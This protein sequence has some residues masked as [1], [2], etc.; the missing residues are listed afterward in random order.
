MAILDTLNILN[1]YYRIKLLIP[2]R[3]QILLRR[4]VVLAKMRSSTH[5]WP[6]NEEAGK[7]PENW[8]GWPVGKRFALVLTHDVDTVQGQEK[9]LQLARLERELGFRSAFNFVIKNDVSP[10]LRQNLTE[11]GFE[12]GVH[13]LVH[14]RS[15]YESREAFRRQAM[16]IN[17]YVA[18]WGAVG[19]RSPSMY[20][21][22]EW[23]HDLAVE[24]DAS[25]F[26]TD[27]FEPQPDGVGTIFPFFVGRDDCGSGYIELPYTLPQD[28]T[29]FILLQERDI[30]IWKRKLDWIAE[31]GGMA[32]LNTHPDY[33]RF[34][35]TGKAYEEYP[36][37]YYLEF[38]DYAKSR[39][40]KHFWHALPR[41][42]AKF[43][44]KHVREV[45]TLAVGVPPKCLSTQHATPW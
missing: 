7:P 15:L 45:S 31:R 26:D 42:I 16:I 40:G 6:I 1:L 25:T 10:A 28:F 41:E 20:H 18:G 34:A 44:K 21:N 19:F 43:Q 14:D 30:R 37:G 24:Y 22:L 23:I 36:V 12:V 35:C 13:G 27:P 5:R 8:R 2:R 17:R 29:L 4:Q 33:M 3:L 32:L 11:S 38:L 9:C 39:Y